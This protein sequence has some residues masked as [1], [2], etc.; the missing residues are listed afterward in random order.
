MN[1]NCLIC[2]RR[3]THEI[4]EL[5]EI[6]RRG[7]ALHSQ[8][9]AAG[10]KKIECGEVDAGV[11]RVDER[12]DHLEGGSGAERGGDECTRLTDARERTEH[13]PTFAKMSRSSIPRRICR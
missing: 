1:R 13:P 4:E 3:G 8:S 12:G 5:A 10:P 11:V 9:H 2:K 7:D 6:S